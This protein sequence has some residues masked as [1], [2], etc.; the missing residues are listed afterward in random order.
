MALPRCPWCG[1]DPLYYAFINRATVECDHFMK[2]MV[3]A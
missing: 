1:T 2:H 3:G